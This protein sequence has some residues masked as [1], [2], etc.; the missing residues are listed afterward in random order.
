MSDERQMNVRQTAALCGV[1]E[2]TVRQWVM[3]QHIPNTKM[4]GRLYF[5]RAEVEA[6]I[7]ANTD[8]RE[9]KK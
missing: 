9:S 6:F 4:F 3:Q 5:D 1:A 8:R 2:S 7:Q